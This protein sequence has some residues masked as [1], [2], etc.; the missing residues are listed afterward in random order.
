MSLWLIISGK[1]V[2]QQATTNLQDRKQ[3]R[4]KDDAAAATTQ[5]SD[6]FAKHK[7]NK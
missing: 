7:I 3:V 6:K 1:Q 2:T 4:A 5:K